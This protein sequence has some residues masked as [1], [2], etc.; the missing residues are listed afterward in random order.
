[1]TDIAEYKGGILILT[2]S[3]K[4]KLSSLLLV[5]LT[6]LFACHDTSLLRAFSLNNA[7][8]LCITVKDV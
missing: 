1:R 3:T 8:F 6:L 4:P 7:T 5:A 2:M